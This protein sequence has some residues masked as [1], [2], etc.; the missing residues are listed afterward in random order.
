VALKELKERRRTRR[1]DVKRPVR[2]QPLHQDGGL[3]ASQQAMVLDMSAGGLRLACAR[4]LE[5][6]SVLMLTFPE[7]DKLPPFG[8]VAAHVVWVKANG[9]R[10]DAGL[11]L[12]EA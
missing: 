11:R 3:E 10:Y 4:E 1:L 8:P 5:Q 6:G 2:I 7:T 12:T 9:E